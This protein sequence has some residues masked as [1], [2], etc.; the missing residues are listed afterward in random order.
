[1]KPEH[2]AD[3]EKNFADNAQTVYDNE[4]G[5]LLYQLAKDPKNPGDYY[6]LEILR[7]FIPKGS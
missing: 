3:F 1:M 4:A 6:V 5:C 2:A 7:T